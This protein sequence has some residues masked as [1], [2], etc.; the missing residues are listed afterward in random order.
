VVDLS[1][2]FA[3]GEQELRGVSLEVSRSSVVAICGPN[4]GGKDA[5]CRCLA[6][7][8]IAVG[9]SMFFDG[10]PLPA[11]TWRAA[12]LGLIVALANNRVFDELTVRENLVSSA[13]W[14]H[15]TDKAQALEKALDLFPALRERLSQP[16]GTLSGGEQQ[17]VTLARALMANPKL[18]VLEEPWLGLAPTLILSLLE[19]IRAMRNTGTSFV[20]TEESPARARQYA[21]VIYEMAGGRIQQMN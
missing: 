13:A 17:M 3:E 18:V 5:L 1:S 9:G 4:G 11:E 10:Q 7:T 19:G 12:R 20:L 2:A 15:R 8:Q 6:G 14:W 16:A 21:D